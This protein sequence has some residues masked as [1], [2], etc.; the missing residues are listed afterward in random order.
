MISN[1]CDLTTQRDNVTIR[2][3]KVAMKQTADVRPIVTGLPTNASKKLHHKDIN[4]QI[5]SKVAN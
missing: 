5:A 3:T 4:T 2:L 1:E